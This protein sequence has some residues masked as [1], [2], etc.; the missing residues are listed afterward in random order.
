MKTMM[1]GAA[2]ALSLVLAGTSAIAAGTRSGEPGLGEALPAGVSRQDA[3]ASG[4]GADPILADLRAGRYAEA[5]AA[6][7][8]LIEK[9]PAGINAYGRLVQAL[10]KQAEPA[11]SAA[12]AEAARRLERWLKDRP[13]NAFYEYGLGL[14]REKQ[15]DF[16]AALRHLKASILLGASFREAYEELA[17]CYQSKE[18]MDETAGFLREALKKFPGNPFLFE[19]IG[20]IHYYS[21]EYV[22]AFAAL[23]KARAILHERGDGRGEGECL[24]GQCD[25]CTYSNDYPGALKK[26]QA[27]LRLALDIGD[28]VLEALARDRCA[29][30]WH[31]LGNAAESLESCRQALAL[32][33]EGGSPMHET[34]FQLTMG[35]ISLERGNLIEAD[36]LI[37]GALEYFR[38]KGA[39]RYQAVCYY[40]LTIVHKNKGNYSLAMADARQALAISR[41]IGFKTSEAFHLT[42]IGDIHLAFGNYELALAFNQEAL[43]VAE[44][45]IGKWSREECLNTIGFVYAELND[46]ARALEYFKAAYDYIERIGHGRE[47]ARCLYN[48]GF[49]SFKLGD[50]RAAAGYFAK[51]L[52]AAVASGKKVIQVHNYNRLGDLHR[53]QG[54][55][56]EAA[57]AYE[58]AQAVGAEIGQLD[59]IWESYAGLGALWA[60]RKRFEP[61]VENYKKAVAIIEDLRVQPLMREYSAGFF[62]SKIPVYEA[63][64]NLLYERQAAEPSPE[65]PAECLYYAEKAK[66]RS[67]LDDLRRARIDFGALSEAEVEE[68]E[69]ISRKISRLS[70]GLNDASLGAEAR[71]D[72]Q[73]KLR[74]AEDEFQ[75]FIGTIQAKN[76]DY[77]EAVYREPR[78]LSEI[79]ARLLDKE[80]GI[81]EYFAGGD[82]LYVFVVTADDFF[83]RRLEA[84]ESR[85]ALRLTKD[86]IRLISSKEISCSDAAPAGRRLST[87]LL[88]TAVRDRLKG[89]KSLIIVPDGT[90]NYLPFETLPSDAGEAADGTGRTAVHYL[91]EDYRISYAPSASTLVSIVERGRRPEAGA[92]LLAVGDPLMRSLEG[93]AGGKKAG[94]DIL[95]EYYRGRRFAL[96]PLNFAS[97]EMESIAGLVAAG[98]RKIVSRGEATEARVKALD[99]A[100]YKILHFATHSLLDENAASRSALV[101]TRDGQSGEDG[102][103]QAGEIY[104]IRLN[105]DLVVLSACQTARGKLGK[106]EGIQGLARA[107]FCAGSK[108][109]VASLWNINDRTTARFMKIFYSRLAQGKTAQEALRLAKLEMC[110]SAECRPYH[111]AAFVLIGAGNSEIPLH[112]ASLWSRLFHF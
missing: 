33:R 4:G 84:A 112:P 77:A 68:Q 49:A 11:A 47:T 107:F 3:K 97:A 16:P 22:E 12:A 72:L 25:V 62:E 105:A 56:E 88:G 96:Q 90:L 23:E 69:V 2:L 75:A 7:L 85:E 94:E 43:G 99:L 21:S 79:R 13:D 93:A 42:A 106:G 73:D 63:L 18:D 8:D 60:A 36:K 74:K 51:S 111:W 67:F 103:L 35:V 110:R 40:W 52:A 82:N 14:I 38:R 24:L 17:T 20:R 81:V 100:G 57:R 5:I 9:N 83:V 1:K 87:A 59:V 91:L 61:A 27:G 54:E 98:S 32:A 55:W 31:D 15:N 26:A 28:K 45:Y 39:L 101:L 86:Y 41:K 95:L 34:R 71:P 80:T 66:A 6:C 37:T 64:V 53:Q 109:V 104:N 48:M 108:A 46:Y 30:V 44:R 29:F 65:G 76:P 89:L 78:R 102:F 92:D 58:R 50:A 70:A 10:D 19:A